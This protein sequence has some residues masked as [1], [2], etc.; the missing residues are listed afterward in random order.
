M[1]AEP[2]QGQW[3]KVLRGDAATGRAELDAVL[4]RRCARWDLERPLELVATVASYATHKPPL[5]FTAS[6]QPTVMYAWCT[7]RRFSAD[8]LEC[9]FC[10]A[11][12]ADAQ[13]HCVCCAV[14]HVLG[15][16]WLALPPFP[17]GCQ[18]DWGDHSCSWS[19][20]RGALR[21]SVSLGAFVSAVHAD[22]GPAPR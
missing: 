14:P 8:S 20:G 9:I 7:S 12:G 5:D 3:V 2:T 19:G 16:E 21:T 6:V 22:V 15:Q 18:D 4:R 1:P 11:E 13:Q 10:H 17:G